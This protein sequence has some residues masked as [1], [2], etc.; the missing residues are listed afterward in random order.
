MSTTATSPATSIDSERDLACET[1]YRFLAGCL[2]D[3]RAIS[4]Q[5]ALDPVSRD[6]AV[7][8]A[9][10]LRQHTGEVRPELGFGELPAEE[11]DLSRF[12]SEAARPTDQ[13]E[14]EFVS[15]FGFVGCRECPPYETEYHRVEDVFFRSQQMAD[16]AG[17]Y[18]AFGLEPTTVSRERPDHLALE[19][20]FEA[21]LLLKK[22]LALEY[23][24]DHSGAAERASVC[25]SARETFFREH[26]SWWVPTFAL[27]LRAKAQC[28]LYAELS[29]L[30]AAF[31]PI[32]RQL[33]HVGVRQLAAPPR[34]VEDRDECDGCPLHG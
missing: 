31:I 6:L 10:I 21:F 9:D 25:Q 17:F 34:T 24:G 16:V 28:G 3:P 30:L 2:S 18:R 11:L 33:L 7:R 5:L 20:E 4:F 26:L 8:A 23:S 27:G 15:V 19:L 14:S 22:R 29:R 1:L 12:L 13:L 32:E